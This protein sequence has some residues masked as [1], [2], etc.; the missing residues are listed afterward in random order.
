MLIGS[1]TAHEEAPKVPERFLIS[2]GTLSSQQNVQLVSLV[3]APDGPESRLYV[4]LRQVCCIGQ[5]RAPERLQAALIP[6]SL[7]QCSCVQVLH[8]I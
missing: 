8:A 2:N 1:S 4:A 5:G 7:A 6:V 3:L